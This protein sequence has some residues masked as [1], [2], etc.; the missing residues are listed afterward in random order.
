MTA[1]D[2]LGARRGLD[3]D[4]AARRLASEGLNELSERQRRTLLRT[5]GSVLREPMLLLLLGGGALY[6]VLG[7]VEEA[8]TLLSFVV[9]VVAIT[10]VQERKTERAL[11]ALR[12]LS[13]PRARVVRGGVEVRIPG[14]EVARGDVTLLGEGDRVP[15]DAVLFE[16][17]HLSIDE[18]MLTGESVPVR[19]RARPVAPGERSEPGGDDRPFVHAGTR[20]VA[21]RGAAEVVA[22]GPRTE[23]GKLG[24]ALETLESAASPLARQVQRMVRAIALVG[25]GLCLV[26]VLAYGASRG[27]Y[28][29]GLLA[30]IALAMAILPEELPV[31]LTVFLALGAWRLSKMRMLTRQVSAVETL[32]AASVLCVDKTGT[33]TE[34][35]MRVARLAVDDDPLSLEGDPSSLPERFHLLV[36]VAILASQ[37]DPFDPMEKAFLRIGGSALEGTEHLHADWTLEREYPLTPELL[38]VCHVWRSP[39]ATRLAVAAKGAPE[40]IFD[41]CHLSA[42]RM[43]PWTER[44]AAMASAGLRVLAVARASAQEP[45]PDGQHDF[46]FELLGLVGLADPLRA[47]APDAIAECRRAGVRV[48]MITGDYAETARAIATAAGLDAREILLGSEIERLDQTA[49]AERLA[50]VSVVARAV[51]AHKL[52]I[53]EALQASGQIVAMTGDGVNDAPA[54]KAAHIGIAM[55]GRGTDVAREAASLVLTDDAFASIVRAVRLARR[56]YDNLRKSMG[57]VVAVHVPIAGMSLLPVLFGWP[58][59]LLPVHIV[60]FELVIDPA[61]SIAFEAEPEEGDV[62]ARPPRSPS[63][64]LFGLRTLVICVVQ[65]ACVLAVAIATYAWGARQSPEVGRALVLATLIAG[66]VAL[67]VFNRSWSA[68]RRLAR[69]PNVALWAVALGALGALALVLLLPP[70][71][72]LFEVAPVSPLEAAAAAGLGALS[73]AWRELVKRVRPAW[74]R[75]TGRSDRASKGSAAR[76]SA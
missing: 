8:L 22:T 41:L 50:R 66:N 7:D 29:R 51:P 44:V 26:L 74:L 67:I 25:L 55:G 34:N 24:K 69:G 30:G 12:N 16:S 43:A 58:L 1:R 42:E 27:D 70:A 56:I 65:G 68:A 62:M 75:P 38:S 45:L 54:L 11:E 61:C 60:F 18:S 15:A 48:V 59:V 2:L 20:V 5:I 39:D 9:I 40:A 71:R 64:P 13:S 36:E 57:Y 23:M 49:L 32:G 72:G 21:G 76:P 6:F 47:D 19:K 33:L 37:R 28:L 10:V 3:P 73:V 46:D 17:A 53:V 14:R 63:A 52:R 35:R 4:E 31:I